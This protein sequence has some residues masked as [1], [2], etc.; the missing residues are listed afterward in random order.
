MS[1]CAGKEKLPRSFTACKE[2]AGVSVN[3]FSLFLSALCSLQDTL[4]EVVSV[5]NMGIAKRGPII[6]DRD[7]L[8]L[9][10]TDGSTCLSDGQKLSYST[11]IHL[12]CSR[13]A[14]VRRFC[15]SQ[16]E[17]SFLELR[18]LFLA[19]SVTMCAV[20]ETAFHDVP[21]LHCFLHVGDQGRLCHCHHQE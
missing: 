18:N 10:F 19:I 3:N 5:S 11:V 1:R 16:V 17:C 12:S 8:L 7:R 2:A 15:T 4:K 14:Q 13:G 6:Q 20:E 9:E 21:E